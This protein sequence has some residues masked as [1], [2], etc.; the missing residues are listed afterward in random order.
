MAGAY[1]WFIAYSLLDSDL[2][3]HDPFSLQLGTFRPFW[4]LTYTPFVKGAAYLRRIEVRNPEQLAVAQLK[5]LKLLLWSIVLELFLINV[6][7]PIV[8]QYL[9]SLCIRTCLN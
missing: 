3:S 6:F 7:M 2:K 1:I 9:E 5:G 8:H 4:G